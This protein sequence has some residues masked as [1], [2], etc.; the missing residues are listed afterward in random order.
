MGLVAN[1]VNYFQGIEFF[2]RWFTKKKVIF[3]VL[4]LALLA[5]L[6]FFDR[7]FFWL[8]VLG[9]IGSLVKF[10]RTRMRI[11]IEIEPVWFSAVIMAANY[12]YKWGLILEALSVLIVNILNFDFMQNMLLGII[13]PALLLLL[14]PLL[15]GLDIVTMG[16][17]LGI[18]RSMLGMTLGVM[19]GVPITAMVFVPLNPFVNAYYFTTFGYL[20]YS[21]LG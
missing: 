10:A 11:P 4:G 2:R 9:T 19:S 8:L 14:V 7:K 6:H 16:I 21:L 12:G 15:S 20:A 3:L 18:L 13:K 17:I 1:T 5:T